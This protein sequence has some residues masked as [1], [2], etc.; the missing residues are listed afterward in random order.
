MDDLFRKAVDQYP[1]KP[2][3]SQWDEL[4]GKITSINRPLTPS[5]KRIYSKNLR[6]T[7]LVLLIIIVPI[8]IV[9][10][11]SP[12]NKYSGTNTPS[13]E[14]PVQQS[15]LEI[16][17]EKK[18]AVSKPIFRIHE[19]GR[20]TEQPVRNGEKNPGKDE[21]MVQGNH[22]AISEK[23]GMEIFSLKA[24]D[25]GGS[26][27]SEL[28]INYSAVDQTGLAESS[29]STVPP[30]HVKYP[31]D[32]VDPLILTANSQT[33]KNLPLQHLNY[34]NRQGLYLGLVF[35]PLLTQV[36]NQGLK[37]SGFD[38]G[39]LIG[40]TLSKKISIETGLMHAKQ[41]FFVGGKYY[42]EISGVDNVN[43]LEGTRNAFKIPL[44]L[45]YNVVRTATANYFVSAGVSSWVGINDK[46]LVSVTDG[47]I[48]PNR[49]FNYDAP[50]Y[51]PSY[52]DIS[53][54]YE[55]KMGRFAN[56][57]IEPYLEIPLSS[58]T[59]NSF[60]TDASGRSLQV[61]NSGIHIGITRFIH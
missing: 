14:A 40:Y 47:P 34:P 61:F 30:I 17:Y 7:I 18:N 36:K 54:G 3:D 9:S 8:I 2:C 31:L 56:I 27:P 58:T 29:L 38:F 12:F 57:R 28:E 60:K 55:Y 5:D 25:V 24:I 43:S 16:V 21:L 46:V 13:G 15:K 51:L 22:G 35:G 45:K 53:L 44:T 33:N 19:P 32:P 10:L 52:L 59:G 39:L 11:L 4:S 48:P 6:V 26:L 42:N 49:H 1:L 23:T 50:S 41:N 37:K 20:M